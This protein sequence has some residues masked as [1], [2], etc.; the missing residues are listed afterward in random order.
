M[1][2]VGVWSHVAATY[3]ANTLRLWVNGDQ[4]ASA[5]FNQ[6]IAISSGALRIGGNSLFGEFFL[7]R[8][9]EVRIYDRALSEEEL[10]TAIHTPINP[11][12]PDTS[13]PTI[14]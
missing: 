2:P 7:G 4:A 11:S 3:D 8:I 6:P 12:G 14:S 13:P 1:L 5:P 10:E 9:D